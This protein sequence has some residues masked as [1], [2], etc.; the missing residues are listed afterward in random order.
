MMHLI[1]VVMRHLP[2][3]DATPS[4][5]IIIPEDKR[6]EDDEW[7][8]WYLRD[9]ADAHKKEFTEK[10]VEF[11]AAKWTLHIFEAN[12]YGGSSPIAQTGIE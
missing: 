8:N 3:F 5:T 11:N 6:G 7:K 2:G 1:G 4:A 12:N 10:F 9:Q